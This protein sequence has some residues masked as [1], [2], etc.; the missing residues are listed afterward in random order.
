MATFY[1]M[2]TYSML[3][4]IQFTIVNQ[5]NLV[6]LLALNAATI[7]DPVALQPLKTVHCTVVL[8][9]PLFTLILRVQNPLQL[10]VGHLVQDG[11]LLHA[12]RDTAYRYLL[13]LSNT[14]FSF[15]P[16]QIRTHDPF[17]HNSF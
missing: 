1:K 14:Q 16:N 12:A 10:Q 2:A 9:V 3:P 15:A 7:F 17:P 5:T 4:V 11:H 8:S 6:L 13:S